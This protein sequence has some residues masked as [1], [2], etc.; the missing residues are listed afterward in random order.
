MGSTIRHVVAAASI[1]TGVALAQQPVVTGTITSAAPLVINGV[2]MLPTA[3]P[4]WP[5]TD[6]TEVGVT[7]APAL[8]VSPEGNRL[9]FEH[10]S[11]PRLSTTEGGQTY[12][13]LRTG[14]VSFETVARH[15]YIC[16]AGHLFVPPTPSKGYLRQGKADAVVRN[17]DRG[18]FVEDG[19]RGCD[20]RGPVAILSTAPGT[21][22][23]GGIVPGLTPGTT[24]GSGWFKA[25]AIASAAVATGGAVANGFASSSTLTGANFTPPVVSP[26]QP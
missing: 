8:F 19:Q 24:T 13:Y 20:E 18:V 16:V 2:R 10:D 23:A 9:L 26:S 12:V 1:L 3:A 4:S 22:P 21:G 14:A 15:V 17:L 5:L 6:A 25:A 7:S 11:K